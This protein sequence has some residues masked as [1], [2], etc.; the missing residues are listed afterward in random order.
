MP[1]VRARF[2][3]DVDLR[4]RGSALVRIAICRCD[5]KLFCRF[6]AK[7]EDRPRS[8]VPAVVVQLTYEKSICATR[9]FYIAGHGIVDIDSI[10]GHVRL[11][12]T[13]AGHVALSSR[14]RLQAE[15]IHHA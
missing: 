2:G 4:T 9:D 1:S 10:K 14:S 7:A 5:A 6:R 15:E 3:D 8:D 11:I 12:S 13:R